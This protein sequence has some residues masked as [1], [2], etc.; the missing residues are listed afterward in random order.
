MNSSIA[1]VRG[2]ASLGSDGLRALRSGRPPLLP[3][4]SPPSLSL[5]LSSSSSGS[6]YPPVFPDGGGGWLFPPPLTSFPL[7]CRGVDADSLSGLIPSGG[8]QG[9]CCH[10]LEGPG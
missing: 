1:L 10:R 4:P 3:L 8:I 9:F 6:G 2:E 5:L 7:F